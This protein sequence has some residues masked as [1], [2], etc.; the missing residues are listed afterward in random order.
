MVFISNVSHRKYLVKGSHLYWLIIH[1]MNLAETRHGMSWARNPDEHGNVLLSASVQKKIALL[2]DDSSFWTL[3]K[4]VWCP[5]LIDR[6][7]TVTYC[8]FFMKA[9]YYT[10]LQHFH[11]WNGT[12]SISWNQDHPSFTLPS[13]TL[14]RMHSSK[15]LSR[16]RLLN[17]PAVA[18]EKL[19]EVGGSVYSLRTG[20]IH[21]W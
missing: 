2:L 20:K 1:I 11:Y 13:G 4:G 15:K 5:Y 6:N 17:S 9:L 21:H 16:L 3:L 10:V 8:D 12:L 18:N 14:S 19:G 7:E